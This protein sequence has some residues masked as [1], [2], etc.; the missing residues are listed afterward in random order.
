MAE[1]KDLER[2][3]PAQEPV[4][5][6]PAESTPKE[7][8]QSKWKNMPRK[9]RRKIVRWA[10]LLVVLAAAAV[11]GWKLLGGKGEP[12]AQVITDM[13]SYGSITSTVEG[14]GLTRARNSQTITVARYL[15]YGEVRIG[16]LATG[17]DGGGTSVNGIHAVGVHIMRQTAGATDTRDDGNVPRCNADFSH[18][19][20]Q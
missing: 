8:V 17:S 10:I 13:V 5:A 15:P 14:S 3:A 18:C 16:H 11:G 20:V 12:E 6:P 4:P 9:K 1:V 19:F 2:E 7:S